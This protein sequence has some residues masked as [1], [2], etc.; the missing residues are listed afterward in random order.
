MMRSALALAFA[1]GAPAMPGGLADAGAA[2]IDGVHFDAVRVEEG[3]PL[4]LR[5]LAT[6][7]YKWLF[8]VSAAGFYAESDESLEDPLAEFPKRLEINY[9]YAIAADD[10]AAMT[11]HWIARNVSASTYAG[12]DGRIE[13]F[14]GLYRDVRPGDRYALTYLPGQGTELSLNGRPLGRIDG[15]DFAAAVFAIWL[16][17]A[18]VDAS[19]KARV[20]GREP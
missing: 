5:G 14:N 20:L 16:G 7:K 11:R 13:A 8:T 4:A 2:E 3:V 1:L 10:F 18:P 12:L 19:F 9:F 6:M 17:D 15:R